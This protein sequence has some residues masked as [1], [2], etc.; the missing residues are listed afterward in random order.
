MNKIH[1]QL[2][3]V[4]TV[5]LLSIYP[6]FSQVVE[7]ELFGEVEIKVQDKNRKLK[8]KTISQLLVLQGVKAANFTLPKYSF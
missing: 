5:Y 6:V 8:E 1:I 4:L 2:I 3:S 7:K